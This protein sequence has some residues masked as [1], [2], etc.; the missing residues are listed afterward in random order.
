MTHRLDRVETACAAAFRT[1][2]DKPDES[3]LRDAYEI[4]R[5]AMKEGA[6]VLDMAQ[7]CSRALSAVAAEP[8]LLQERPWRDAAVRFF[9]EA[10]SPF[11][12][13][14]RGFKDANAILRR[15]NQ[16]LEEQ[17][18]RMASLLHDEAGQLLTPLHLSLSALATKVPPEA[19]ADIDGVRALLRALEERLR[20]IAHELRPPILDQVGLA[21]ALELLC[22][23]VSQRWNVA[24]EMKGSPG[25]PLARSVETTLYRAVQEGLM[26]GARHARATRIVVSMHRHANQIQ[27][28]VADDGVGYDW[29]A[30]RPSVEGLG[31]GGIR[32]RAEAFGGTM[33][34]GPGAEQR[35]TTLTLH[36]PL[37]A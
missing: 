18:C 33:H 20:T 15:V 2:I 11:E 12:M 19:A 34:V 31:L 1:Y 35:G 8:A 17:A 30:G 26:N 29:K 22:E 36:I 16:L 4:G 13:A 24:I 27:C 3:A 14:H 21:A 6:G 32:E 23:S 9:A 7:V 25:G 5:A 10:L 28:D 37:E